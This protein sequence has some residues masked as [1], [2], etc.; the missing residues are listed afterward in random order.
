MVMMKTRRTEGAMTFMMVT[1][2]LMMAITAMIMIMLMRTKTQ[3]LCCTLPLAKHVPLSATAYARQ[4]FFERLLLQRV[5]LNKDVGNPLAAKSS[6]PR[7]VTKD[8]NAKGKAELLTDSLLER[9]WCE[10]PRTVCQCPEVLAIVNV[11]ATRCP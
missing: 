10:S 3:C 2:M 1:I 9:C 11:A 8:G 4:L 7:S 6:T 5:R